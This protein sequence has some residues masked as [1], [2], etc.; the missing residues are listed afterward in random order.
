MASE[1]EQKPVT[2]ACMAMIPRETVKS[3]VEDTLSTRALHPENTAL[4]TVLE[5]D[6]GDENTGTRP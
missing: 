1:Q 5:R 6:L 2:Q 4:R 3:C